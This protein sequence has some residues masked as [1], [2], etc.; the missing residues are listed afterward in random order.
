MF[1]LDI[2]DLLPNEQSFSSKSDR[3]LNFNFMFHNIF[4]IEMV[5]RKLIASR[6]IL[7]VI[8]SPMDQMLN[9]TNKH[10]CHL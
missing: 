6:T 3:S 5:G 10:E 8:F 9:A 7:N 4:R 2:V 1:S